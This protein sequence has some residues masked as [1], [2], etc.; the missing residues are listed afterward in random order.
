MVIVEEGFVQDE[1]NESS[2]CSS[3][4]LENASSGEVINVASPFALVNALGSNYKERRP[5]SDPLAQPAAQAGLR[6][7]FRR[8]HVRKEGRYI[9]QRLKEVLNSLTSLLEPL[10]KSLRN[11]VQLFILLLCYCFRYQ[12]IML[13]HK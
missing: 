2:T 11:I 3:L 1:E 8:Q 12:L 10:T 9:P 5:S 7:Q 4:A 6:A 13:V